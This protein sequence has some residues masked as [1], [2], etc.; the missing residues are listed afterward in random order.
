VSYG[1]HQLYG[2]FQFEDEKRQNP[3]FAAFVEVRGYPGNR[4]REDVVDVNV[5]FVLVFR[6]RNGSQ[7]HVNWS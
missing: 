4:L 6:R 1:A 5:F 3:A 2:K 7:S